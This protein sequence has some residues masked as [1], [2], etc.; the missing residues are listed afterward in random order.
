[1]IFV[2]LFNVHI[3]TQEKYFLFHAISPIPVPKNFHSIIPL[4]PC[5]ALVMLLKPKYF[6][7]VF[8]FYFNLVYSVVLSGCLR[9]YFKASIFLLYS[10]TYTHFFSYFRLP[11]LEV[12]LFVLHLLPL[13]IFSIFYF[14]LKLRCIQFFIFFRPWLIFSLFILS[15]I[16]AFSYVFR[17]QVFFLSFLFF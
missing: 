13:S 17:R 4:I 11:S 16:V 7:E 3:R 15:I 5:R 1:M 8:R 14:F 10:W 6:T 12:P 9:I 2:F